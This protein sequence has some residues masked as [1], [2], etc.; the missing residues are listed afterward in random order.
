MTRCR[1]P[2]KS[3]Q[4]RVCVRALQE[5]IPN[6]LRGDNAVGDAIAAETQ[7]EITP[8]HLSN[9][10]NECEA[11]LGFAECSRPSVRDIE[12]DSRKHFARTRRK[13]VGFLVDQAIPSRRI[14]KRI[15]FATNECA[16]IVGRAK[17]KTGPGGFPDQAALPPARKC[18]FP[19][20]RSSILLPATGRGS[21]SACAEGKNSGSLTVN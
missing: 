14:A 3:K 12:F 6:Y 11:I 9:L 5:R 19:L 8:R 1:S 15:I 21:E 20:C 2:I 4:S 13:Q 7:S 16:V 10:A 18:F 17:I